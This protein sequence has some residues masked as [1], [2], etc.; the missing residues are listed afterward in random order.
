MFLRK[1]GGDYTT[2][3]FFFFFCLFFPLRG[4]WKCCLH[5]MHLSVC[6]SAKIPERRMRR[7]V[8]HGVSSP[9]VEC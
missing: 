2:V 3:Y 6:N 8:A 4:V 1:E 9:L 7:A 5:G